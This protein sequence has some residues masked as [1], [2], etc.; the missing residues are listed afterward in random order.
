MNLP[1]GDP[2]T[3]RPPAGIGSPCHLIHCPPASGTGHVPALSLLLKTRGDLHASEAG[4]CGCCSATQ[5]CPTLFDPVDCSTPGS[6]VFHYLP[7]SLEL[8]MLSN[9]LIL[10][11]PLLFLSSILP[12]IC[13]LS[14][15]NQVSP[16]E[17]TSHCF[18]INLQVNK[19]DR[20]QR[21]LAC[22]GPWG[23]QE[24]DKT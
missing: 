7:E 1:A 12:S 21:S 17:N 9:H 10:C 3:P 18:K 5:L 16:L 24:S 15:E 13:V 8:V 4:C 19:E 14:N 2:A 6:S 20:G 23:H 22:C 11:H